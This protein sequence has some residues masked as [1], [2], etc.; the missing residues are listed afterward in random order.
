MQVSNSLAFPWAPGASGRSV[1]S[2][3]LLREV[4]LG[5]KAVFQGWSQESV[6]SS[7]ISG[8]RSVS[9]RFPEFTPESPLFACSI[10][11]GFLHSAP[12]MTNAEQQHAQRR[13]RIQR[14]R[15]HR[16]PPREAREA[17]R[18]RGIDPF[19]AR[20]RDR[21]HARAP[22]RA[23]FRERPH[24]PPRRPPPRHPRHGQVASSSSLG[25]VH[26]AHPGL[27]Q[28]EGRLGRRTGR[29]GNCSTSATGSA[30]R[31]PPSP[32]RRASRP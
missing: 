13:P 5:N 6:R 2:F 1:S 28:P 18:A 17:P 25:D 21:H 22:L 14:S 31:A 24:R 26:G 30:S 15:T 29:S 32:P 9:T 16:G 7:E 23:D 11:G 8:C 10:A 12:S 4:C 3:A 20:F 27:P 19:G